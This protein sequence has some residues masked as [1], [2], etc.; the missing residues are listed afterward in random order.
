MGLVHPKYKVAVVQAAPVFLDLDATVDKTIALIDEAAAQGARLIAFPETVIPG[1][2]WWIW[3][4][5]PAWAISAASF[6]AISIIRWSMTARRRNGLREAVKREQSITVVMGSQRARRRQPLHRPMDDRPRRRDGR[7]APQAQADA[8]RAH[9][10]RRRR[11]Q[12]P[13][14]ARHAASAGSARCA[15]GSIC[16]RCR[17]TRCTRRTSKCTSRAWP[18]FSL[19]AASR[20]RSAPRSTTPRARSTRSRARVSCSRPARRSRRR[21]SRAVRHDPRSMRSCCRRR[22]MP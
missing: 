1:Y 15:A 5:A 13:R 14:G 20:M 21:W 2:P 10:V 4:G 18:S 9:G 22:L 16:S 11:R 7:Q 6:S 19:Y 3:L 8:C 12:R 17:N